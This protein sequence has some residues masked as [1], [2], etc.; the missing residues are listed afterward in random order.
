MTAT[1]SCYY[2]QLWRYNINYS[3]ISNPGDYK[4]YNPQTFSSALTSL[5]TTAK[6]ILGYKAPRPLCFEVQLL[7]KHDSQQ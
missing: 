4:T 5:R 6:R 7:F 3:E 1:L 2:K